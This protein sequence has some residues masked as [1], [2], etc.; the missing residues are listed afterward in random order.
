MSKTLKTL[1]AAAAL[2][3]TTLA[4][5]T[6]IV[7][8]ANLTIGQVIVR[9][10]S[11][12][13]NNDPTNIDPPPNGANITTGDFRVINTRTG[14]F[15]TGTPQLSLGTIR[16]MADPAILPGDTGNAFPLGTV[17]NVHNF[18]TFSAQP[19]WIFDATYLVPGYLGI[20]PFVLTQQGTNVGVTMTIYGTACD[21]LNLSGT[22]NAGDDITK[23]TGIFSAQFTNTTVAEIAATILG[24]GAL[25]NNTWSA[26]IEAT[27]LPEPT[28]VA[29]V[30]LALAGVGF[31]SRRRQA[32]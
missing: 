9:N 5:A 22:C 16:D 13:W 8:I 19:N 10:G 15:L 2:A 28:S 21:D 25:G 24:G 14:S 3:A 12:D 4:S 6:P 11:V 23:W 20:S 7:G 18:L 17:T 30:G 1:V 26:T 32:K 29:L 27:A 31:V